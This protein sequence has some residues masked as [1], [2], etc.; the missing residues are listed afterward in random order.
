MANYNRRNFVKN[1]MMAGVGLG[2]FSPIV[3]KGNV[4]KGQEIKKI[5]M[6]GLD[7]GH[8]PAFVKSLNTAGGGEFNN[9]RVVAA[10]PKGT[11]LV[12][13]WKDRIPEFTEEVKKYDVD[14]VDS[15]PD[16]LK[17]VDY[18]ILTTIDGNKHL[19]QVMPVLEAGLPVFIDKPFAASIEDA[20]KIAVAA[21]KY[22]TPVFS[23]SSLRFLDGASGARNGS[24]GRVN[25]V[26]AYSPAYIEKHHPD[27]YWY[28]VHGV[29]ILYTILGTGCEWAQRT[30]TPDM[31]LVVGMWSDGKIG[32]FRGIRKGQ[33]GYGGI[34]YAE[35]AIQVLDN[36]RG[37]N[38]L[39]HAIVE[40]FESGVPPVEMEETLEI[41]TF[42]Q[43]AEV[44]KQTGG[45]RV[46]LHQ[47]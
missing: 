41:F 25:G 42:M 30:Y 23:S 8:S 7:T 38:G 28:G 21:E 15:I 44:S 39:L 2:L 35:K 22:K 16:L 14:I 24:L 3:S 32:T 4:R 33:G 29:E 31:D 34:V 1:S 43:A 40:F 19:E 27:L 37:Y 26:E 10:Y 18:V 45:G 36:F 6:I 11:D 20:R 13:E 5:G 47:I 17:M 12:R 9:Y 46:Y